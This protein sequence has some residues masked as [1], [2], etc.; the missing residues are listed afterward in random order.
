MTELQEAA[1]AVCNRW[2]SPD[3]SDGTHALDYI[4][5]LREA[6]A[7]E[8]GSQLRDQFAMVALQGICVNAGRNGFEYNDCGDIAYWSYK[9][10]NAMMEARKK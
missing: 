9:L 10:A 4:N 8:Q 2:D 5:R 1:Q 6:I 7:N 3:W